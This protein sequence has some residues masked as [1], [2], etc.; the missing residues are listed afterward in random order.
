MYPT[1]LIN[2]HVIVEVWDEYAPQKGDL[3]AFTSKGDPNQNLVKRVI[4]IPGDRISAKGGFIYLNGERER[5]FKADEIQIL[6][7]DRRTIKIGKDKVFVLGDNRNNSFDSLDFGTIPYDKI[8]GKVVYIYWP[9]SRI[10]KV[11]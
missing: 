2:D 3:I 7:A 10:G 9:P 8:I 1:L 4:G 5:E 11:E 6:V